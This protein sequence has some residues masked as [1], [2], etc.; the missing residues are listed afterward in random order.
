MISPAGKVYS[1]LPTARLP[2]PAMAGSVVA[3]VRMVVW[4]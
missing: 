1:S 4:L 2:P 3:T